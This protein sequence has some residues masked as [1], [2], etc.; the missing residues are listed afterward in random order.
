MD[1]FIWHV[2]R[3]SKNLIAAT[4]SFVILFQQDQIIRIILCLNIAYLR[5]GTLF[6]SIDLF[7]CNVLTP[8]S[9]ME[10]CR[11]HRSSFVKGQIERIGEKGEYFRSFSPFSL[12]NFSF[13]VQNGASLVIDCDDSGN[14]FFMPAKQ[15]WRVERGEKK[16]FRRIF[17]QLFWLLA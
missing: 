2:E 14:F 12:A 13:S 6:S 1:F 16:T 7:F 10:T 15:C 4:L 3:F 8:T 11:E 9:Q 5:I 17:P